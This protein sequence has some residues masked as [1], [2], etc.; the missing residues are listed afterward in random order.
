MG[1]SAGASRRLPLL[2]RMHPELRRDLSSLGQFERR[3]SRAWGA[4]YLSLHT[5]AGLRRSAV[6]AMPAPT[7][8]RASVALKLP[9]AMQLKHVPMIAGA[10]NMAAFSFATLDGSQTARVNPLSLVGRDCP[11]FCGKNRH[12]VALGDR[13]R[14]HSLW[15]EKK[16]CRPRKARGRRPPRKTNPEGWQAVE[17]VVRALAEQARLYRVMEEFLSGYDVLICPVSTVQPFPVEDLFP[18]A[19]DGEKQENYVRWAGFTNGLSVAGNPLY[20]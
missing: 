3:C 9:G 15:A 5:R 11:F 10:S 6:N 20:L 16:A 4:G 7:K 1:Q 2:V 13:F 19:V 8:M 18:K 14:L 17:E 12:R